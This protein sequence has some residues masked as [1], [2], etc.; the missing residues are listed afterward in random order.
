MKCPLK[1]KHL[2]K[3]KKR[4]YK[5]Q[6]HVQE[7]T[8]PYLNKIF[9]LILRLLMIFE[10]VQAFVCVCVCVRAVCVFLSSFLRSTS[11]MCKSSKMCS[12]GP[13]RWQTAA[14]RRFLKVAAVSSVVTAAEVERE[15]VKSFAPTLHTTCSSS[16]SVQV[17]LVT[18][19]E[20]SLLC[21]FGVR[22][23]FVYYSPVQN[24]S[25]CRLDTFYSSTKDVIV[26][27]C[28][29]EFLYLNF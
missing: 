9:S 28:F 23:L 29:L 10:C 7:D 27:S 6:P 21:L 14:G 2:R 17:S 4:V 1:N 18:F 25:F 26:C 8:M 22:F 20:Q 11:K 16:Q 13:G 3:T 24:G 15:D 19:E 5:T 12:W